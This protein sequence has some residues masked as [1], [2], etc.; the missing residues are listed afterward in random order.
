[1]IFVFVGFVALTFFGCI[2]EIIYER[3]W[4]R[5]MFGKF[6]LSLSLLGAWVWLT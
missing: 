1:M 6:L 4:P 2:A 5:T 3:D